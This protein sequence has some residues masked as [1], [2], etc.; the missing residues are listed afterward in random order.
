MCKD[1]SV[2][3]IGLEQRW[4]P[5]WKDSAICEV[6]YHF[7]SSEGAHVKCPGWKTGTKI[8]PLSCSCIHMWDAVPIQVHNGAKY[9]SVS[10]IGNGGC[11]H[12]C[13][14]LEELVGHYGFRKSL[15]D[16]YWVHAA[17]NNLLLLLC[18]CVTHFSISILRRRER[19]PCDANPSRW[20]GSKLLNLYQ[21]AFD[22]MTT[23]FRKYFGC[24]QR[25]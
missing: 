20:Q 18:W 23:V 2:P 14:L 8:R 11:K 1:I 5:G 3:F 25:W 9:I 13:F 12:I 24:D 15:W 19:S 4:C 17:S 22:Q 21:I 10:F 7:K 16:Y 6:M